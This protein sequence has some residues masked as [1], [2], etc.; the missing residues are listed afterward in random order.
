MQILNSSRIKL[1]EVH[2]DMVNCGVD[3]DQSPAVVQSGEAVD[4]FA[5]RC[6]VW[7]SEPWKASVSNKETN[8]FRQ[9]RTC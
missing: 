3:G 5:G 6:S 7:A 2:L 9:K 8:H 1:S 4:K